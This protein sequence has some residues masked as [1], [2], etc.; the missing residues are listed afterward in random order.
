MKH[1]NTIWENMLRI[2]LLA[3]AVN[4]ISFQ[5]VRSAETYGGIGVEI[6]KWPD[7]PY[8]EITLIYGGSAAAK[9]GLLDYQQI[10]TINGKATP[11]KTKEECMALLNGG[12]GSSV[13][14]V[15]L[16]PRSQMTNTVTLVRQAIHVVVESS[17]NVLDS[18][19]H[20]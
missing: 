4:W 16:N 2:A 13:R 9:A 7:T 15:L 20:G 3:M 10:I 19:D 14:L 8:P 11:G 17:D 12:V 5:S 1:R 18:A 6:G